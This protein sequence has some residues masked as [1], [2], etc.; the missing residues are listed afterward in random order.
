[1]RGHAIS[2]TSVPV[3]VPLIFGNAFSF[4]WFQNLR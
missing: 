4:K 1:M 3:I 2:S